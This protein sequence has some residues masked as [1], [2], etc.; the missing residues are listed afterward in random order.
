MK[1]TKEKSL[2]P[3]W[4]LVGTKHGTGDEEW[5]YFP[6]LRESR[7][8]CPIP[9]FFSQ[10]WCNKRFQ[11][12][13]P[14]TCAIFILFEGKAMVRWCV[15]KSRPRQ[16]HLKRQRWSASSPRHIAPAQRAEGRRSSLHS[17]PRGSRGA[18]LLSPWRSRRRRGWPGPSGRPAC[19]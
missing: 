13:I 4:D 7:C 17:R 8:Y 5:F 6:S 11:T 1:G 15:P 10:P 18:P 19:S 9:G 3:L 14:S 12:T 2:N 16:G